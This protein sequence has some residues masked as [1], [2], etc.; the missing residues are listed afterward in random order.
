MTKVKKGDIY[1]I[2]NHIIGC[3]DSTDKEFVKE[4]VG[5]K[6]IRAVLTDPPYGVAYVENK[7]GVVD[8][9]VKK[10]IKGDHL[11][12]EYEYTQFTKK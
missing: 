11:Q 5:D 10:K 9:A 8:L 1:R 3:G 7:K 6:K 12:T 2:G 4:V